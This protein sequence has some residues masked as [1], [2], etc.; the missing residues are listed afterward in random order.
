MMMMLMMM[1]MTDVLMMLHLS[2]AAL[3]QLERVSI[4]T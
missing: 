3:A 2:Q 1:V 4:P